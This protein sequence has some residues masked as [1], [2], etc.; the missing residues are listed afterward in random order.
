MATW[1]DRWQRFRWALGVLGSGRVSGSGLRNGYRGWF[2]GQ[3]PRWLLLRRRP[4]YD[5]METWTAAGWW[6][7]AWWLYVAGPCFRA[8]QRWGVWHADDGDYYVRGHL[9]PVREWGRR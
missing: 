9:R 7:T 5:V 2:S 3:P 4:G 8:L 6:V 1:R